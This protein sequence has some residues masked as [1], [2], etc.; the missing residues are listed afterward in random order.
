MS[1]N[2]TQL[3]LEQRYQIEAYLRAGKKQKEVA[4]I[5]GVSCSTICRELSRNASKYDPQSRGYSACF[6]QRKSDIRHR[7]KPKRVILGD[8]LKQK[9]AACL[10]EDKWSPEFISKTAKKYGEPMISH[11]W[12]YKW[13]WDCK[14]KVRIGNESYK[15]LYTHLRHGRHRRKRGKR[16]DNRGMAASIKNRIPIEKRPAIVQKRKRVGDIEV[17]LMMGKELKEAV[18]VMTDRA[19]LHTRL[20]KLKGRDSQNVAKAII[21]T[22]KENSYPA[23]TLTFDN[24]R[25]FSMHEDVGNKVGA[26]TFFTRPYTSQDKGTVENRIGVLRRFIPKRTD[27]TFISQYDL[28]RIEKKLNNRP[29]RKFN[30]LTANQ[31]LKRKIALIS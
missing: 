31:V 26:S 8:C 30:Y 10:R 23:H 19:T 27:L 1:K 24:D 21:R 5:I 14:L 16:S 11:E 9:I 18:L 6:A 29:I 20:K 12:I 2:Y 7:S 17:D 4:T 28:N 22:I 25:A 13:I 15:D 3:S